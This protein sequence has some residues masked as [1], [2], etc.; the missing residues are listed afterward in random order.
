MKVIM[1][2]VVEGT[3]KHQTLARSD[4]HRWTAPLSPRRRPVVDG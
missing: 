3:T 4:I 2:A 1:A